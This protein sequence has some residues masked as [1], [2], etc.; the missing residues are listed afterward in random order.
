MIV[1]TGAPR[2]GTSLI[3]QILKEIG[4][5]LIGHQW[6]DTFGPE[7]FNPGGYWTLTVEE[8]ENGYHGKYHK[9]A[10][11]K[12][13]GEPLALTCPTIIDKIIICKRDPDSSVNSAVRLL[14]KMKQPIDRN[15]LMDAYW[16]C[17]IVSRKYIRE[18]RIPH[19]TI[20]YEEIIDS[21]HVVINELISFVGVNKI[22]AENAVKLIRR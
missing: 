2:T 21:P 7:E 8:L 6:H 18:N 15:I 5:E 17:Y 12:I 9:N 22:S 16:Y 10:A 3:M 11:I 4:F 20:N 13:L 19:Y 14:E 1:V